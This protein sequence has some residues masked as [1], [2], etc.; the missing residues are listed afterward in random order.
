ML[1]AIPMYADL[2]IDKKKQFSRYCHICHIFR[3]HQSIQNSD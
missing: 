1:Q 3:Q 2:F